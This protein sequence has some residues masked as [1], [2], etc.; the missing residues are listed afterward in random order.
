MNEELYFRATCLVRCKEYHLLFPSQQALIQ[1][2][3]MLC[4]KKYEGLQY[5]PYIEYACQVLEEAAEQ[6]S[7]LV[8]VSLVRMNCIVD[9]A[10]KSLPIKT[11]GDGIK[12]PVWMHVKAARSE[13]QKHWDS[14]RPDVQQ[15]RRL[16]SP[17]SY[18][19]Y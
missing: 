2:S 1:D 7:D 4:V 9:S 17:L 6:D 14:L 19:C 8:L 13:L 16:P 10:Y 18:K 12:A 11:A 15:H 5:S 3:S